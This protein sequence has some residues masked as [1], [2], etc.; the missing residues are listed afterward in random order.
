MPGQ[1]LDAQRRRNLVEQRI[2]ARRADRREHLAN[3]VFGVRNERHVSAPSLRRRPSR[4]RLRRRAA[5]ASSPL[6][7]GFTLNSQPCAVRIAVDQLR[8]GAQ[9][10]VRGDHLARH[11]AVDVGGRLHGLDDGGGAALGQRAADFRHFDEHQV[12]ERTL[13]VIGDADGDGAVAFDA[14][15]LVGVEVLQIGWNGGHGGDLVE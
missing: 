6:L 2:D 5:L 10:L 8:R 9:R 4:T 7:L 13:R 15:P 12:A 14:G 3:V 11:R 1:R